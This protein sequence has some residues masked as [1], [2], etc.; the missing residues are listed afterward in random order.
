MKNIYLAT[1]I[2]L[3]AHLGG[4]SIAT[5]IVFEESTGPV[6]Y[7]NCTM[8]FSVII[9]PGLL[10]TMVTCILKMSVLGSNITKFFS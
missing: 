1:C 9:F 4:S 10:I 3:I 7:Y 6:F 5:I 2:C 8:S